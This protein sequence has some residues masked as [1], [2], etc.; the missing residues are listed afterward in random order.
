M[1]ASFAYQE[2]TEKTAFELEA[3]AERIENSV[4]TATDRH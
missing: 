3:K 4:M 1:A 2:D